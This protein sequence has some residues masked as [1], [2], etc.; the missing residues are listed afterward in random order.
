MKN[1][2]IKREIKN[3]LV[4]MKIIVELVFLVNSDFI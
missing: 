1:F 3:S 2:H 4:V